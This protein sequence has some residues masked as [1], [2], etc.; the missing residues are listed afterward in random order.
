MKTNINK[1]ELKRKLEDLLERVQEVGFVIGNDE[2]NY[3][4]DEFR[5]EYAD[6]ETKLEQLIEKVD[7]LTI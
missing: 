6:F 5:D 1:K 3:M 2:L 7:S 4:T